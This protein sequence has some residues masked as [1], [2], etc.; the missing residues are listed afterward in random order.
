MIT[1][2]FM[3]QMLSTIKPYCVVILKAG[4]NRALAGVEP[5][6]WEHARSNF[7]LRKQGLLSIVCPIND[8]SDICGISVFNADVEEVTRIMDQ[9]PAI[10]G[11]NPWI[12]SP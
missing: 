10:L 9:D 11:R 4:P 12:Q 5:V 7:A 1:D 3:M 2:E 6:I 8:D